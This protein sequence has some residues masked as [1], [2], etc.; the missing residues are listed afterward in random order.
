M[1]FKLIYQIEQ[2]TLINQSQSLVSDP[3]SYQAESIINFS[4][5]SAPF[6]IIMLCFFISVSRKKTVINPAYLFQMELCF[7]Q[8]FI[9]FFLKT[10]DPIPKQIVWFLSEIQNFRQVFIKKIIFWKIFFL[11]C[12]QKNL[13]FISKKNTNV[14]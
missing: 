1:V 3:S 2:I 10:K 4:N 7:F 8:N 11:Q 14:E 5:A 9:V 6:W 13:H 12:V